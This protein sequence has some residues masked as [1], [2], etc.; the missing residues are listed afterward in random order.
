ML[1]PSGRCPIGYEVK[2]RWSTDVSGLTV[3]SY[4][5]ITCSGFLSQ[6]TYQT[7]TS[8]GFKAIVWR[9]VI[10]SVTRF[11]IVGINDIPGGESGRPVTFEVPTD[12]RIRVRPGDMIGW[13]FQGRGLQYTNGHFGV[14]WIGGYLYSRL[15]AG[16]THIITDGGSSNRKYSIN[17]VIE[18]IQG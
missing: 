10:G 7:V 6:W 2:T 4:N 13:S 9:L 17:A 18:T 11:E 16:Q 5:N 3:V 15:Q 14:R 12:E 8:D 1:L